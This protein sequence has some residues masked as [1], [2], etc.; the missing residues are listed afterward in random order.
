MKKNLISAV[1]AIMMVFCAA[2]VAVMSSCSQDDEIKSLAGGEITPNNSELTDVY[3][4]ACLFTGTVNPTASKPAANS[5]RLELRAEMKKSFGLVYTSSVTGETKTENVDSTFV[6]TPVVNYTNWRGFSVSEFSLYEGKTFSWKGNNFATEDGT[7][8]PIVASVE[9]SPMK[10]FFFTLAN[11]NTKKIEGCNVIATPTTI[12]LGKYRQIN[13][14]TRRYAV[15]ATVLVEFDEEKK[16]VTYED[17]DSLTLT[18]NPTDQIVRDECEFVRY[19]DGLVVYVHHIEHSIDTDKDSHLEYKVA[20]PGSFNVRSIPSF[21]QTDAPS[22]ASAQAY[23]KGQSTYVFDHIQ[24]EGKLVNTVA[25]VSMTVRPTG[26]K[27]YEISLPIEGIQMVN[28]SINEGS[29]FERNDSVCT[30][31]TFAYAMKYGQVSLVKGQ[32]STY[33]RVAKNH[34]EDVTI[35]DNGDGSFTIIV[36]YDGTKYEGVVSYGYGISVTEKF[37]LQNED[38]T[39]TTGAYS[40]G[41]WSGKEKYSVDFNFGNVTALKQTRTDA[42]AFNLYTDTKVEVKANRNFRFTSKFTGKTYDLEVADAETKRML[43]KGETTEV[44]EKEI[45]KWTVNYTYG[46]ATDSQEVTIERAVADK[47]TSREVI[48]EEFYFSGDQ[49]F[50][51]ITVREIHKISANTRE[52]SFDRNVNLTI[53]NNGEIVTFEEISEAVLD[54]M[55]VASRGNFVSEGDSIIRQKVTYTQNARLSD[56]TPQVY[57]TLYEVVSY[58]GHNLKTAAVSTTAV[59]LGNVENITQDGIYKVENRN[60]TWTL[61]I[62]NKAFSSVQKVIK[63]SINFDYTI[64][65]WRVISGSRT[66]VFN[67]KN[68]NDYQR[69]DG[70]VFAKIGDESQKRI[71]AFRSSDQTI[72]G[73][74]ETNDQELDQISGNQRLSFINVSGLQPAILTNGTDN[75]W[76]NEFG[77]YALQESGELSKRTKVTFSDATSSLQEFSCPWEADLQKETEG[78][79]SLGSNPKNLY[80]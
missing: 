76:K 78:V 25:P 23:Q 80:K 17:G 62:E 20:Y 2:F 67:S 41:T 42:A 50:K 29:S 48:A 31:Y 33:G 75:S 69:I 18:T 32:T 28:T 47:V 5:V 9:E 21:E 56:R 71:Y 22:I 61:N 40:K 60:L 74:W 65:G 6:S 44:G 68:A 49:L 79:Y 51:R 34:E 45:Q 7:T 72:L 36:I 16:Y 70:L 55:M 35:K 12:E 26:N 59:H 24:C 64:D 10:E 3:S 15:I 38:F 43:V 1:Y 52:Y 73:H 58:R 53:S 27:D 77:Y 63:Y 4:G 19:E 54:G 30:N 13:E 57:V 37:T 66:H 8:L 39:L 14:N 11:G 46:S